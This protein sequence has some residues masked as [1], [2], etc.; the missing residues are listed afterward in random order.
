[1]HGQ[2]GRKETGDKD[3]GEEI[4]DTGGNHQKKKGAS[5]YSY[6]GR[7]R[8]KNNGKVVCKRMKIGGWVKHTGRLRA[9]CSW[10]KKMMSGRETERRR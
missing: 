3:N 9:I 1:M 7:E 2:A 6:M 5:S 10:P 4:G 8:E